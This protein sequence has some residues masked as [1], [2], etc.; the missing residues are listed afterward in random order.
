MTANEDFRS[1]AEATIK[2]SGE[3]LT[4]APRAMPQMLVAYDYFQAKPKQIILA[5][6][7]DNPHT[8]SMLAIGLNR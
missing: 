1:R 4:S 7:V 6:A 3:M 5:G 2:T 8:Q